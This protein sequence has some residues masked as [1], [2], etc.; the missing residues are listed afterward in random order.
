MGIIKTITTVILLVI[1]LSSQSQQPDFDI[2]GHRGARGIF[3][4]NSIPGFLHA[5]EAGVTT[6]EL[7]VVIS[8]DR[9]VVVSHEPWMSSHICS[10][11]AGR[12]VKESEEK[13]LNLYQM[14]YHEIAGFDCGIRGNERFPEQKKMSTTKPL[15]S[16]VIHAVEKFI[17]A[18]S[19]E[20]VLYN[21]EIKSTPEGDEQ[22][23]PDP[24]EFA[25][26]VYEEIVK[27]QIPERTVI[28][29]FDYRPLQAMRQLD[30]MVNL[31]LL[32]ENEKDLP[33]KLAKLGFTPDIYSPYYKLVDQGLVELAHENKMKI[34]PWTVNEP[35]EMERLIELGVDGIITD[36]PERLIHL[37]NKNS[38]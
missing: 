33:T 9:K 17:K 20:K 12:P 28:Q 13:T 19:H 36:Y 11:P 34:I 22:Y 25:R 35:K 3:P 7:D 8:K 38:R 21:I 26:L 31:S 29:S 5:V 16:E 6:L 30:K 23:H 15:L 4:E 18:G 32:V 27:W 2:Q 14:D 10:H 24:R 37:V 1:S